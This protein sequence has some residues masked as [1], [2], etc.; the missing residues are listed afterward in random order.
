TSWADGQEGKMT[1]KW[2]AATP[3]TTAAPE[4]TTAAPETTTEAQNTDKSVKFDF[5]AVSG[6]SGQWRVYTWNAGED[7]RWSYIY[8]S[9]A[10]VGDYFLLAHVQ[11]HSAAFGW[12]SV[13]VQTVDVQS[14]NNTTYYVLNEK[15]NGKLKVSTTAPA[16]PETTVAPETTTAAPETTVAPATTVPASGKT[17]T[18]SAANFTTGDEDWY[19][20]TWGT[21]NAKWVKLANNVATGLDSNVIFAR[22]PKGQTPDSSWSNVWNQTD[23][24][25]TKDG[26]TFVVTSWSGGNN[27]HLGGNWK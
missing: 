10:T 21:G 5:S 2:T 12:D 22:V 4:T 17:A 26:G 1:G 27:G 15:D 8:N 18:L 23:D 11:D 3:A 13:D 19:A 20:Y 16:A 24:Q 25:V 6:M 9:R 7:G 14:V